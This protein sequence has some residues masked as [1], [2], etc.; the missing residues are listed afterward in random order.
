MRTPRVRA[1]VKNA[2]RRRPV[3]LAG[4]DL[5]LWDVGWD[6][7]KP[8]EAL[9]HF[10]AL[11][12]VTDAEF[13]QLDEDAQELAFTVGDVAQLDMVTD[14]WRAL[15]DALENGSTFSDFKDDVEDMLTSAWGDE[16]SYRVETIF[17]TNLQTAY[18]YGRYKEQVA[19][20][21]THPIWEFQAIEDSRTSD[22]CAD[23]DGHVGR[24]DDDWFTEHQPPLHYSCRSTIVAHTE[25]EGPDVSESEPDADADPGFGSA[26][27]LDWEPDLDQYPDQLAAI[28]NRGS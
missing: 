4:D 10:R 12:P 28:Y 11:V 2:R 18:S 1:R 5:D 15:D 21:D 24:A 9:K 25:D 14:V 6:P 3:V 7:V 23:C 17:R 13:E 16:D 27:N 20:A 26:P 22:I 19:S 8:A